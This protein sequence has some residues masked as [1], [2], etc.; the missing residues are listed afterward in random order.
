M[1]RVVRVVRMVV[2]AG[3]VLGVVQAYRSFD[4]AVVAEPAEQATTPL[5]AEEATMPPP[6]DDDRAGEPSTPSAPVDDDETWD[7]PTDADGRPPE[8]LAFTGALPSRTYAVNSIQPTRSR[9]GRTTT[10]PATAY[11]VETDL[12]PGHSLA[13][14]EPLE[15]GLYASSFDT[16]GCHYEIHQLDPSGQL[17][18]IGEDRVPQGRV[19]VGLNLYEPD[20]FTAAPECGDWSPWTPVRR[21]LTQVGNGDYW[22]GDLARGTWSVPDGCLWEQVVDFRGARLSDVTDS[23]WGPGELVVDRETLGVR[24]R[25]CEQPL[26]LAEAEPGASLDIGV[27]PGL[28]TGEAGDEA[29]SRP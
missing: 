24:V 3:L 25:L 14:V 11:P 6:V 2:V 22:V 5:P 16:E 21:P 9:R 7:G 4:R 20:R 28:P 10:P 18:L 26:R 12:F 29:P 13:S 19:L 1:D 23:G 27:E 15:P 17:R 8:V